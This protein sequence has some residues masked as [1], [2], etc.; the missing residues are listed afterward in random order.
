MTSSSKYLNKYVGVILAAGF[1][2]RLQPMT[3]LVPK[4]LIPFMGVPLL[5]LNLERL[6]TLGLD[7]YIVNA[8]YLADQ[9]VEAV[10]I[11][12]R[13]LAI[14]TSVETEILG[15]GGAYAPMHKIR[16]GRPL[17]VVN[18]DIISDFSFNRLISHHEAIGASA[19]MGLLDKPHG[20]SEAIIWVQDGKVVRI[21]GGRPNAECSGHGYACVQVLGDQFLNQ[22]KKGSKK[23]IIS[24]YKTA[25]EEGQVIGAYSEKCFWYDLGT[26]KN[27]WKAH[28][29]YL[30]RL[31]GDQGLMARD[32]LSVFRFAKEFMNTT[33]RLVVK[34]FKDQENNH[35]LSPSLIGDGLSLSRNSLLGPFAITTGNIS[36]DPNVRIRDS[37]VCD[38]LQLPE[39]TLMQDC[40]YFKGMSMPLK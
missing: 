31:S 2:S 10:D 24:Y 3:K 26:P 37:V 36:M 1:G 30:L 33:Y 16:K 14:H 38:N 9:I 39:Q 29:D 8:H 32:E 12:P 7:R 4:P 15:T 23:P 19:S 20:D 35:Y 27:Y 5:Y 18:G 6:V 17:V 40:L 28:R 13:P 22:I 34:D 21:G 25:L 11:Y